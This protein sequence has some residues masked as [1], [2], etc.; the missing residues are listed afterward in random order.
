[1]Y[2]VVAAVLSAVASTSSLANPPA[3]I[4]PTAAFAAACYGPSVP[5]SSCNAQAIANI[6]AARADEGLPAMTLPADYAQ[7][8]LDQ[9]MAAVTNAER[10]SR[11]LPALPQ[12]A[13]DD[14]LAKQGAVAG[15]DP[16][17]PPGH[18]WGAIWAGVGDPLAADYLWMYDDGPNS[19]NGDCPEPGAPGCW[20]HRD[21][22]LGGSWT[23]MGDGHRGASLA[24]I[25]VN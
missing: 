24:E 19:P 2:L 14:R 7:L 22:I 25:F 1:M 15:T 4:P 11:G 9:K 17:G 10:T 18:A 12:S 3:S 21:I 23:T 6:D 16:S 8:S 20:G 5:T 13:A